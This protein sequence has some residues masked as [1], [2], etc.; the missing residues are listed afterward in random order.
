MT[1]YAHKDCPET[2]WLLTNKKDE[3]AR[4]YKGCE[5]QVDIK[6]SKHYSILI[7]LHNA[8]VADFVES[9]TLAKF[10]Y[11]REIYDQ[12]MALI[13]RIEEI[14]QDYV[15]VEKSNEINP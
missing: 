9:Q 15:P 6:P 8:P 2:N 4:R 13:R 7:H 1:L 11:A 14:F 3:L 10:N 12:Q 5:M